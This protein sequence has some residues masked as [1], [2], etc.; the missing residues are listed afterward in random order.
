MEVIENGISFSRNYYSSVL[1]NSNVKNRK[2]ST[3][4]HYNHNC[5]WPFEY[6]IY[7][8]GKNSERVD[9]SRIGYS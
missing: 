9:I 1:I 7:F 5:S 3:N 6:I 4:G 2:Q 8:D